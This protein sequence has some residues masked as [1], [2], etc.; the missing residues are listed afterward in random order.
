MRKDDLWLVPL[1]QLNI[2][3]CRQTKTETDFVMLR[4]WNNILFQILTMSS[5][6]EDREVLGEVWGG[7]VPAVFTLSELDQV[8]DSAPCYIMLPRMSYLP[9]AT[10]KVRKH[11]SS[12]ISSASDMWFSHDDVPLRWHHPIG[13]LYD[14]LSCNN[15]E[16]TLPWRITVHF[17][18]FPV[19][20]LLP[21][22]TRD[23]V[24]TIIIMTSH[25]QIISNLRWRQCSC[26]VWRRL[27]SWNTA[28]RLCRRCRRKIITSCGR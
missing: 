16:L 26:P 10:D 18:Q 17:S 20:T 4:K 5:S 1:K 7:Q 14:Q 27:I 23:Q 25:L 6:W 9:L 24:T 19:D 2:C 21:C 28:A 8:T 12:N 11:F 22:Q 15:P 13:L 3:F